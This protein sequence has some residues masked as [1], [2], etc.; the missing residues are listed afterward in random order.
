MIRKVKTF[1]KLLTGRKMFHSFEETQTETHMMSM[2]GPY[3]CIPDLSEMVNSYKEGY[4]EMS[5]RIKEAEGALRKLKEERKSFQRDFQKTAGEMMQLYGVRRFEGDRYVTELKTDYKPEINSEAFDMELIE[6]LEWLKEQL[7]EY[8][9][10]TFKPKLQVLKAIDRNEL[11][12]WCSMKPVTSISVRK[13]G[14]DKDYRWAEPI[15][16]I[17]KI[18]SGNESGMAEPMSGNTGLGPCT[19]SELASRINASGIV[20]VYVDAV[21]VNRWLIH[22]GLIENDPVMGRSCKIPTA[23]GQSLGITVREGKRKDGKSYKI[24]IYSPAAQQFIIDNLD[25]FIQFLGR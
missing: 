17:R 7:P 2:N 21:S 14:S 16:S 9:D 5:S 13:I 10:V 1:A 3:P 24:P 23:L 8:I 25:G 18:G 4:E 15:I 6:I 22:E 20:R 11:P 12:G 19:I